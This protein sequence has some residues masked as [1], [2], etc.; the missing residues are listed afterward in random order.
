MAR[1]DEAERR[2]GE[3]KYRGIP[4]RSAAYNALARA[5]ENV[6]LRCEADLRGALAEIDR[7]RNSGGER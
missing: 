6:S 3:M 4:E 2:Y 1:R 5:T 7:L